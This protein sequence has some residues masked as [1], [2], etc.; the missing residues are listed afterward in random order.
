MTLCFYVKALKQMTKVDFSYLYHDNSQLQTT[1][2]E[3]IRIKMPAINLF[4]ARNNRDS[5]SCRGKLSLL[6]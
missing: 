3:F 1:P 5:F 6:L 4:G 2:Q